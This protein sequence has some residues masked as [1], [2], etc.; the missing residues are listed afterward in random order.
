M[1]SERLY[2]ALL[3]VYPSEHRR[4]YGEPMVQLFRDRMRRDGGGVKTPIVWMQMIFDLVCS[5]SR[6][7]KEGVMLEGLQV[8]RVVVRSGKFLLGSLVGAIALYMATT[9]VVLT[10]GLV[11][12]VMGWYQFTI[13]SGPLAFLGYTMLLDSKT[14]WAVSI[15]FSLLGF[16][17]LYVAA[18]LLTGVGSVMRTLRTS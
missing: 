5:A 2:R 1:I 11:S 9:A 4:E 16:F 7:H 12:L 6:G 17:M 13:E 14:D 15:E 18:A 10:A 3:L 8:K